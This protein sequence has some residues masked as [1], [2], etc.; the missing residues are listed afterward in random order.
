MYPAGSVARIDSSL[1][2][3]KTEKSPSANSNL[4]LSDYRDETIT[5]GQLYSGAIERIIDQRP[6][7]ERRD[8]HWLVL[9]QEPAS[10]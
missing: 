1:E 7:G 6:E 10:E 8:I 5:H 3:E 2:S 9:V 4:L